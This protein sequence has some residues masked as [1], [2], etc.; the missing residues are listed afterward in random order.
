ML[1]DMRH[2][3]LC[4][5]NIFVSELNL[6]LECKNAD[7]VQHRNGF[8]IRTFATTVNMCNFTNVMLN[9]TLDKRLAVNLAIFLV[10]LSKSHT[11]I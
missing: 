1:K 2:C 11:C 8:F 6:L 3:E 9:I 4:D 7:H 10:S 5:G